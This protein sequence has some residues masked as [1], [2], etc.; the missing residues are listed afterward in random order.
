MKMCYLES[1]LN[2]DCGFMRQKQG[3]G[4]EIEQAR[5]RKGWTQ[6]ELALKAEFHVN[7]IGSY[8]RNQRIPDFDELRRIAAVLS[9]DHFQIN[10]DIRVEFSANG[11][12]H[13]EPLPEQLTLNLDEDGGV[14]VRI[15]PANYSVII[16]KMLA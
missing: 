14:N 1:A 15:Q 7:T 11:K 16:R 2:H 9:V 10:D 4:K 8:E 6:E 3:L 12:P 5:R 13:Q